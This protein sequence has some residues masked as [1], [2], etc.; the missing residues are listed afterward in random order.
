MKNKTATLIVGPTAIGKTAIAIQF[1]KQFQCAIINAD[2]RQCYK[3]LRIGV[4]RPSEADLNEVPHYFVA[5][6][7][8]HEEVNASVFETLSLQWADSVFTR[9]DHLVVSGG[10]GLYLKAFCEGLDDIPTVQ[11]DIREQLRLEYT[12]KG[13]AWLQSAVK[14]EDPDFYSVGEIKNPARLLRALEVIRSTGKSVISFRGKQK[15]QRPFNIRVFG[16]EMDRTQLNERINERVNQ[17][18]RA[19]LIGE[20]EELFP[21]RHLQALQTVGYTEL[22]SYME[23]RTSLE[24]AVEQIKQHTRQYAKRQMTWFKKDPSIVWLQAN[25]P[26]IMEKLTQ[27]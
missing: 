18:M 20:A 22:F 5:S 27:A 16:L 2:S 24:E 6:H 12:G 4:A 10:T 13:L 8:I 11:R 23:G 17:M 1:A 19:G 15:K 21:Y 25:D 7:S 14:R 26:A 3:E 9:G